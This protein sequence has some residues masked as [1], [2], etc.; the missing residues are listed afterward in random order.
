MESPE[1]SRKRQAVI[2]AFASLLVSALLGAAGC[3]SSRQR[4]VGTSSL[5]PAAPPSSSPAAA[6]VDPDQASTVTTTIPADVALRASDAARRSDL[7]TEVFGA[8]APEVTVDVVEPWYTD[9]GLV[10]YVV[11]LHAPAPQRLPAGVR[12]L[13][14]FSPRIGAS[15]AWIALDT[16]FRP[17]GATSNDGLEDPTA[18]SQPIVDSDKLGY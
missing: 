6:S 18:P 11:L 12:S 14:G 3:G 10:G 1:R 17:L 4:T 16:A 9:R 5:L 15:T 8:E 13:S 2:A 7:A